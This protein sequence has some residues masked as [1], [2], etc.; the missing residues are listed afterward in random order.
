M[1]AGTASVADIGRPEPRDDAG[2]A[3]LDRIEAELGEVNGAMVRL[4]DG[5]YGTCTVCGSVLAD[6]VLEAVPTARSCPDHH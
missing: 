2:R 3:E 6:D 4:D 1:E 5:S